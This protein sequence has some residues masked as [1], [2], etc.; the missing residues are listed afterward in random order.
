M[1]GLFIANCKEIFVLLTL[2]TGNIY[3]KQ[4]SWEVSLRLIY[5]LKE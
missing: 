1:D 2:K 5:K 3:R 4:K